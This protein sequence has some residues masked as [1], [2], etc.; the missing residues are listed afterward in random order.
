MLASLVWRK[1][2][3]LVKQVIEEDPIRKKPLGGPGYG[4]S[5]V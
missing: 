3:F 1:Q 5:K 4:G 2:V